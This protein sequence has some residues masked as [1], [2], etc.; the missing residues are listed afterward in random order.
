MWEGMSFMS[1]WEGTVFQFWFY[2]SRRFRPSERIVFFNYFFCVNEK[3]RIIIF[4]EEVFWGSV[5]NIF[6]HEIKDLVGQQILLYY[7]TNSAH[8]NELPWQKNERQSLR[9]RTL[10]QLKMPNRIIH[11]P[12]CYLDANRAFDWSLPSNAQGQI[13]SQVIIT[14]SPITCPSNLIYTRVWSRPKN[15]LT[16]EVII[17]PFG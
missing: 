5:G 1:L 3:L 14:L 13:L 2:S 6:P 16:V 15:R 8:F 12:H 9:W 4:Y 17:P 11:F 7:T 10:L